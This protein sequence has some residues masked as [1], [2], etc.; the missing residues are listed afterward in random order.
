LLRLDGDAPVLLEVGVDWG[1]AFNAVGR[2]ET[3]DVLV[4]SKGHEEK[5]GL[6]DGVD[7]VGYLRKREESNGRK[8]RKKS[9]LDDRCGDRV[10]KNRTKV[11]EMKA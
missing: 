9:Q 7:E 5:A 10:E 6:F 3:V 1:E 2:L 11:K 4:A 8:G